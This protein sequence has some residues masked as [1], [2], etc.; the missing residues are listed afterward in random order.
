MMAGCL[1]YHAAYR[2]DV[3]FSLTY[4]LLHGRC[5]GGI[6][7]QRANNSV[8]RPS[9]SRREGV[10]NGRTCGKGVVVYRADFLFV[11]ISLTFWIFQF[12]GIYLTHVLDALCDRRA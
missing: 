10:E 11:G 1:L 4:V 9:A 7:R 6:R 5:A 2:Y 12:V 8:M 3:R